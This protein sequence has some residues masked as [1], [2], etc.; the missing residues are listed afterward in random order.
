[1]SS[2]LRRQ[3]N[4]DPGPNPVHTRWRIFAVSWLVDLHT[5]RTAASRG[6]VWKRPQLQFLE[7]RRL[8][9]Y[10]LYHPSFL[11]SRPP[12]SPLP[13]CPPVSL[14]HS[15]IPYYTIA[16]TSL[17]DGRVLPFDVQAPAPLP[18]A[19]LTYNSKRHFQA[20][21]APSRT[22]SY[23]PVPPLFTFPQ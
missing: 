14:F 23:Y 7:P 6:S 13:H 20:L 11:M 1:M 12:F 10:L 2:T 4:K 16:R 3:H 18:Y 15:T 9:A 5:Q 21:C 19:A 17:R 22:T 8:R